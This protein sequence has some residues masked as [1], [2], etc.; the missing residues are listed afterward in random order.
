MDNIYRTEE[1]TT[2]KGNKFKIE[3]SYDAMSS[4]P[5]EWCDG[6]GEVS[7]WTSRDK[8]PG[9]VVLC[10]DGRSK[11]FYDMQ[12]AVK[13]ARRD[14]WDTA[15]YNTGTKGEQARRVAQA[16]YEYLKAWCDN[17]WWYAVL[18]AVM[19]DSDGELNGYAEYLGGVEDGYDKKFKGYVM[20]CA[21]ELARDIET[22]YLADISKEETSVLH[23]IK[24]NALFQA[25]VI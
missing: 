22:R 21:Q 18:H 10:I 4:T 13:I 23:N 2:A 19:L 15:P 14:G 16:D 8:R 9:E 17:N 11:R 12:G 3:L 25:G 5:W 6:H 7:E 24:D 20:E 1:I